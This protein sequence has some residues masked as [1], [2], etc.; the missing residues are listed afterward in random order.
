MG[1]ENRFAGDFAT[2]REAAARCTGYD[3][4]AV[5]ERVRDAARK[6]KRG[7]ALFERDAVCFDQEDYRW[8]ALACM[9]LA[10]AGGGGELAVLD[11]GGSLGSFYFQ[12]RG[13][14]GRQKGL[15][16]GIVEQPRYVECGHREFEDDCL[17]F[18]ASIGECVKDMRP[19]VILLSSVLQY[20]EKPYD[21]LAELGRQ[22]VPYIVLDRTP[23]LGGGDDRLMIQRVAKSIYP[24]SYPMW[25]LAEKRFEQALE[26]M[27]YLRLADWRSPEGDIGMLRFRGRLYGRATQ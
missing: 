18:Y 2:W 8:E 23:F 7:E 3:A 14:L 5:F 21:T 6:V 25:A 20:L 15:R 9:A 19:N 4:E 12:H 22:N 24:A 16:W 13:L 17:K 26:G 27:G 10:A 11:F 1:G